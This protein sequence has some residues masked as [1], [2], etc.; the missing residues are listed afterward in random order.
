MNPVWQ[1]F[2][3]TQTS[4]NGNIVVDFGDTEKEL[5]AISDAITLNE[6]SS[7]GLIEIKGDDAESFLQGQF[8]NDITHV[9]DNLSQISSYSSP[10]GRMFAI[11]R[12]CRY[13]DSYLLCLPRSILASVLKRISMYVMMSKVTLTD[14][15]DTFAHMGLTGEGSGEL[16]E[17][18][19]GITLDNANA[20]AQKDEI[21]VIRHPGDTE[22]YQLIAPPTALIKFWSAAA[23]TATL[24]GSDAWPLLDIRAG[25][26]SIHPETSEAFVAQMTNLQTINGINFKK[27]CYPGQEIVARM[28][29]LGKLKRQMYLAEIK[30]TTRPLPGTT[31]VTANEASRQG[32]GQVVDA[33][34][35]NKGG[36]DL[37]AVLNIASAEAGDIC[38]E[39]TDGAKLQFK[40]L[41]YELGA[42]P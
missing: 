19:T 25:I 31:L 32:T 42:K 9:T 21:L 8:S 2:I 30:T 15:S 7:Y 38:V 18:I 1:A 20:V 28:H 10:K 27:G 37:L 17:T 22:R 41:P 13:S 40:D 16:L 39:N 24:T 26:P 29:Y 5:T 3:S 6:L 23:E 11:F 36:F 4:V 12:L 14:V 35:N 33:R 34:P